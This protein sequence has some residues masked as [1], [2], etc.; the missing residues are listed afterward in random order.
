M[1]NSVM[2]NAFIYFGLFLLFLIIVFFICREL[3][4]WYF[5]INSILDVL[6]KIEKNTRTNSKPGT[7]DSPK[8]I[9]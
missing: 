6:N 5:K 7:G 2:G 4:C 3:V 9:S 8:L 1:N